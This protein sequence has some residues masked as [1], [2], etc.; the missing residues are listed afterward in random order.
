MLPIQ[1][2]TEYLN[3]SQRPVMA[4]DQ[5]LYA[6]AKEI[7]WLKPNLLGEDK[8]LVMMG[9]LHTEMNFMASLGI[10]EIYL[11]SLFYKSSHLCLRQTLFNHAKILNELFDWLYLKI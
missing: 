4:V 7:Q 1:K 2:Q 11:L 6:L 8:F 3:P 10:S 5:P 9:N